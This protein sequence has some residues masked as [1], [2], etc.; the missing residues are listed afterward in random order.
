MGLYLL[1]GKFNI[2]KEF[3]NKVCGDYN[4]F[5]IEGVPQNFEEYI[6]EKYKIDISSKYGELNIKNPFGIASGQLSNSINQIENGMKDGIGFIVLKTV[7]AEDGSGNSSMK[8]WKINEPKMVI[9]EIRS[10]RG[11]LGYT[12]TWKGRGWHKSFDEYLELMEKSVRLSKESAVPVI[13]SCK[14]NLPQSKDQDF[15]N[16]EYKYTMG[17]FLEVWKS[18]MGSSSDGD[19]YLEKDF[20]PTLAGSSMSKVKETILW[21]LEE[22]PGKIREFSKNSRVFLGVKLMNATFEDEFQ[23]EMLQT[24][25]NSKNSPDYLICFNRLFDSEKVFEGKKGVAYGGY[26][27][28]DRNLK[29]LITLRRLENSGKLKTRDIPISATGNICSGKMMLEYAL[30]GC[31]NGQ[32]HTYFQVSPE[33]YRM[34][35]GTRT[36]KALLELIMNPETGLVPGLQYLYENGSLEKVEGIIRF[37]DVVSLWKQSNKI[38]DGDED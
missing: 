33:N 24:I 3:Q 17:K 35:N 12:T 6:L 20:S 28:S 34:K 38:T 18:V 11:E 29:A 22:V 15:K 7:I 2:N 5:A 27:L 30:R 32:L 13:P 36:S 19:L 26:D 25:L 8:D 16:E 37:Q 23:T 31:Q 1:P 21:W 10:Q 9:E 4:R 14:F